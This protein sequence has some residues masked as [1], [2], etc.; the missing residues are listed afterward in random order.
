MKKECD[1]ISKKIFIDKRWKQNIEKNFLNI[2]I[3]RGL[4]NNFLNNIKI[5][6]G[7]L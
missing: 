2:K 5:I 1:I 7:E 6:R 3:I 4:N